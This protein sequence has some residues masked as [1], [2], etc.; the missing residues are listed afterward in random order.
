MKEL[1]GLRVGMRGERGSRE[2]RGKRLRRDSRGVRRRKGS[3]GSKARWWTLGDRIGFYLEMGRWGLVGRL[4][5][6]VAKER[7]YLRSFYSESLNRFLAL[8]DFD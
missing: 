8:E 7:N 6:V 5:R 3:K 4:R 1:K 2:V